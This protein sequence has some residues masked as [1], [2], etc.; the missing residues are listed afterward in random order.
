MNPSRPFIERPV[1]TALLMVAIVLSGLIG[2]RFLPISA[3]PQVDYPT[4]QV[5]T[6]YPGGSPEVMSQ[7]VT[8]PLERNLGEMAGLQRMSSI[9]DPRDSTVRRPFTDRK[10]GGSGKGLEVRLD[11]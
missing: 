1:A 8:A 11:L 4:I 3:L 9:S 10:T 7:T 5:Q 2:L 6:L